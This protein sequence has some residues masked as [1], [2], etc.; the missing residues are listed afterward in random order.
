[1]SEAGV[2]ICFLGVENISDENIDF[3]NAKPIRLSETR[4]IVAEL[5]GQGITVIGSFIIGNLEDTRDTIY[6]NFHYAN[7]ID[8]D[9]PLFLILTPFPKTEIREELLK[10]NLITNTDDYS[11]YDLFHANVKTRH[12]TSNDLEKIRDEIAFK[13]FKNSSRIWRLARRFPNFSVKLLS[14]QLIHQPR[15]VFGY[16][17]GIFK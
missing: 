16:V 7:E 6:E 5:Q 1:M 14:D 10:H 2:N 12:L 3:L 8:V 9:I 13:I 17:Q 15:E 4:E 11:R